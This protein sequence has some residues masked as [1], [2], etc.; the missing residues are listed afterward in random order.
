[1][2]YR[3]YSSPGGQ[4]VNGV[5]YIYDPTLVVGEITGNFRPAFTSD[6]AANINVSGLNL[7]VGS[8]AVTGGSV[9]ISNTTPIPVSGVVVTSATFDSSSIV[10]A[11]ASGNNYTVISNSLLS[12]ISGLL[13]GPVAVSGVVQTTASISSVAVTGGSISIS[14]TAPIAVSGVVVTSATFD[15]SS[16]VN[17]QN[18]GN[19]LTITS[20]VL[21]S[22]VSGLLSSNLNDSAWVTGQVSL[23]NTAPI[24]ISGVVQTTTTISSVAVTGGSINVSNTAPIAIS[25]VVQTNATFDSTSIVNA[26]VSGNNDT[27]VS[28]RLL[29]GISGLLRG[30]V[31]IS[32]VVQTTATISNIAVTGGSINIANTAP[33]AISGVVVTNAA[34]TGGTFTFDPTAIVDAQVSGNLLLSGISGLL[35]SNLTD[36]AWVTGQV[37]LSNTAPIAISGVVVTNATF[38]STSIVNAQVSGNNDTTI[39]NRLLSGISGLLR[40]PVAVSGVIV[41]SGTFDSTSIV[42]AQVTGNNLTATSNELLSAVSGL[43]TTSIVTPAWVTGQVSLTSSDPIAISGVVQTTT[44]ISSVAVTG[45]SIAINNT[46]PIAISGV[47]QTTANVSS[48]AVTGGSIAISNTAPIAISGVVQTNATFDSTSIVNAQVSG[49]NNTTVTNRLLSGISGLLAGPEWVTGQVSL[50]NTAPIAISG[51]VVTN[52]TF[53]SS[54]IVNAQ[55]TGNNLTVTSNVLLSGVSG[56]LSLNLTDAAWVTGAV[57]LTNTAPIAISGVVQTTAVSSVAVTGGSIAV[58][59]T[60]PIAISGVVVTSATFDSSSIVNAQLTGNN[61]SVVTN[62]LLSGIS[63]LLYGPEWI[64]GQVSLTNTAPIAISGVVQTTAV[65]SVA[66]T[67]GSIAVSNTAPIA[68]SGVVQTNATFD[69]TSIVNAQV[70]GNNDT[71]VSNRLLSG[72]SGLLRGPVAISGVVVTNATITGGTFTFDPTA[73]VNSQVSGNNLTTISNVLLSG[74]SGL[75]TTAIVTP[76]WVTGQVSLS[77]TAP[78]AISGVVVAGAAVTSATGST[79]PSVSG[80]STVA[81]GVALQTNTDRK[82][83]GIQNLSTGIIRLNFAPTPPSSTAYHVALRG[84]SSLG[85]GLGSSFIDSKPAYTGPVAVSGDFTS[86]GAYSIW[87]IR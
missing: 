49:N 34:I 39:S 7:S 29:S 27:T 35:S 32:G 41:S 22:G 48:V 73:I 53:D 3:T 19:N 65:S 26:Q 20:N 77:N 78:I 66:V 17:A 47:V 56:L 21:L 75:L 8:V 71:T 83:W 72:I 36:P 52:A 59:N 76:A 74:V 51:V 62:A 6:F 55:T 46:A 40:G 63:G 16:I 50:T 1:M 37:S 85:D 2:P 58:S 57:A 60:A 28:N 18:T 87:E 64:T 11:Q 84:G 9:A 38:D 15:S 69:S 61:L 86:S 80:L 5:A 14:N 70:S 45:G 12:G 4:V 31:S 30:P 44:N 25:G 33:I 68:I 43:L 81:W 13:R 42:N 67:G 79:T 24:A 23:T 82:A 10:N 54:S